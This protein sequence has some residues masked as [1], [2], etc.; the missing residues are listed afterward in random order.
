MYYSE[1]EIKQ[2][3]DDYSKLF[4]NT[5]HENLSLYYQTNRI[6]LPS[7]STTELDFWVPKQKLNEKIPVLEIANYEEFH[8]VPVLKTE[9][10]YHEVVTKLAV[11]AAITVE[12]LIRIR[13][14]QAARNS[15]NMTNLLVTDLFE[16]QDGKPNI[17]LNMVLNA[18]IG[19]SNPEGSM[20]GWASYKFYFAVGY[21]Q[22][23]S[24][25]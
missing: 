24:P 1:K 21:A 19:V 9:V 20:I 25:E 4:I 3:V 14:I 5:V 22:K 7:P 18:P 12:A 11:E 17:R 23:G 2:L 13:A 15:H 6:M 10:Y 16:M 8:S